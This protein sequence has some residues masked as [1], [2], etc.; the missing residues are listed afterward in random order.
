[1][2][3]L[4]RAN[5]GRESSC[6]SI[7][8]RIR[9][10]KR[11]PCGPIHDHNLMRVE[12]DAEI[13]SWFTPRRPQKGTTQGEMGRWDYRLPSL[14]VRNTGNR[15]IA[16]DNRYHETRLKMH[17][18]MD[19]VARARIQPTKTSKTPL[20]HLHVLQY[21]P[22]SRQE[23]TPWRENHSTK[24]SKPTRGPIKH[25]LARKKTHV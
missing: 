2:K 15:F 7:M 10:L 24:P 16:R 13:T 9:E 6:P 22:P 21:Q 23:T 3:A 1:M 25:R 14:E 4:F 18:R 8:H 17:A 11:M 5:R 12:W 19:V 20:M